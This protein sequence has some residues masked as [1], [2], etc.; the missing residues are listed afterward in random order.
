MKNHWTAPSLT[1]RLQLASALDRATPA[2]TAATR[3]RVRLE[4]MSVI[5]Q[6]DA[7]TLPAEAATEHLTRLRTTLP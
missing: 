7:G 3:A 5:S 6:V 4:F 2:A 1:A